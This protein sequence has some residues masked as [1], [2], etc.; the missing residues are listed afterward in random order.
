MSKIA[1]D[2]TGK[3]FYEA[4]ADRGVL[5][6]YDSK[7]S[8]YGEGVA[9]NG[10][11]NVS[12]SP[13]GAESSAMYA[14]NIKY[15]N[16]KSNED[17]GGTIEAYTYPDEF[18]ECDG[19]AE[20]AP[21]VNIGQQNRSKFGFAYR[22]KIGNDVDGVDHGYKIH[23]VYGA[24]A[25]PSEKSYATINESPEAITLSWEFSTTP[26]NVNGFKPTAHV[27]IDSTKTT[28]EKMK[29]LEDILYGTAEVAARLPLPDEV[30]TLMKAE[31]VNEAQAKG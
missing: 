2:E 25:N 27:E 18:A 4:G 30:A 19:S 20:I 13:S 7:L 8:T 28:A 11:T 15:A 1:W 23:L 9:W 16:L 17:F 26:V 12:Q 3:R 14:D 5:Y 31:T 24:E 10:L 22:T 6:K 29:A 21:G